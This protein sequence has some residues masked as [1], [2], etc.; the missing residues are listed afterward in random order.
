MRADWSTA[1]MRALT[2]RTMKTR[3]R[4]TMTKR[5]RRSGMCRRPPAVALRKELKVNIPTSS[6]F[7]CL[8]I[9]LWVQFR[10]FGE[11]KGFLAD[12]VI[13]S[14]FTIPPLCSSPVG[15]AL[16]F[17]INCTCLFG[18]KQT[19]GILWKFQITVVCLFL[20]E[21][22]RLSCMDK[23]CSHCDGL[24]CFRHHGYNHDMKCLKCNTTWW[25]VRAYSLPR[26][27]SVHQLPRHR[28]GHDGRH[29]AQDDHRDGLRSMIL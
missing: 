27:Q 22:T 20:K 12:K 7:R 1:Q 3:M 17:V 15:T 6:R 8:R 13:C 10:V 23:C 5:R 9:I 19:N 18:S 4:T 21:T 24:P 11:E 28:G 2:M 29:D 14:S 25:C 26:V 16:I